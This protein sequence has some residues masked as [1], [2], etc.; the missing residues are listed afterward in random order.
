MAADNAK[1][2]FVFG[3]KPNKVNIF[4]IYWIKILHFSFLFLNSFLVFIHFYLS[5]HF[6]FC[7]CLE[8]PEIF[9]LWLNKN[10]RN[11]TCLQFFMV[12]VFE[13]FLFLRSANFP[14]TYTMNDCI[15]KNLCSI[16][17]FTLHTLDFKSKSFILYIAFFFDF[18]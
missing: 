8:D 16:H 13:L 7:S 10:K 3:V 2:A 17:P 6:Y 12:W 5:N 9:I 14:C 18:S 15:K 1:C 11:E 4:A